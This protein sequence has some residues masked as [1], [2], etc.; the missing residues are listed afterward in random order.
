[1][2]PLPSSRYPE[3]PLACPVDLGKVAKAL[4]KKKR[5]SGE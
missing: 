3:Q 1:L 5:N 2:P 4:K